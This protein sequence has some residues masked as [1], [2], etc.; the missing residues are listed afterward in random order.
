[1]KLFTYS[2]LAQPGW[3]RK[4]VRSNA[5]QQRP[6]GRVRATSRVLTTFTWERG[7]RESYG[8]YKVVLRVAPDQHVGDRPTGPSGRGVVPITADGWIRSLTDAGLS[9]L[10]RLLP[11]EFDA[12]LGPINPTDA[13][14]LRRTLI[15]LG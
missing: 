4:T 7:V 13:R 9:G 5:G 1:M 2:D 14:S 8:L 3:E 12:L 11:V 15:Q 10:D 6:R